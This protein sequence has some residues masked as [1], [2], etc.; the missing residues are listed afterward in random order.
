MALSNIIIY[1]ITGNALSENEINIREYIKL[2]PLYMSF[3]TVIYAP[4]VEELIFRKSI[5]NILGNSLVFVV[6][7]GIIFGLVHITSGTLNDF[8][9]I[10]PYI[11]MG[12]TLSY[13]YY[14]SDNIFTTIT[15]HLVHNFLLLV[16]QFI[17][18]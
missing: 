1:G 6:A 18:G 12:V 5:K 14:K 9:T 7:S 2:F 8:L 15:L 10:I 13:I 17:G 4:I 16:L 3:S 11:L